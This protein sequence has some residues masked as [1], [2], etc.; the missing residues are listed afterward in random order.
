MFAL[1]PL[2][3]QQPAIPQERRLRLGMAAQLLQ[4]LSFQR[5]HLAALGRKLF[6]RFRR[7]QSVRIFS[8]PLPN[9]RQ[10]EVRAQEV[11]IVPQRLLKTA[12]RIRITP[13][14]EKSAPS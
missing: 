6:R 1:R 2:L 7:A 14:L 4:N 11:G 8:L 5:L 9:A 3:L 10:P 12:F 13:C